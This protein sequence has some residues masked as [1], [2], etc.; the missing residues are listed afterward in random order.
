MINLRRSNER[1]SADHGWLQTKHTFSFANYYDPEQMGFSALRVI[2]D[3]L[4]HPGS[5]FDTHGHK[6]M[7]IISVVLEGAIAHKD[8]EGNVEQL[9]AGEFQLMSA[10]K[11]IFHSEF[12]PSK[13]E[14]LKLLQIWIEPNTFG[15]K[16]GYQ[17]KHFGKKIGITTI[18]SPDGRENS[19]TIKQDASLH[20]LVLEANSEL[21]FDI[22]PGRK[23][24][25][26]QVEGSLKVNDV[27]LSQGDGAKVSNEP[28]VL[29]AN[30][31]DK[32][33]VVLVF[34]LP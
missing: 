34:D 8:S 5:G 33:I 14:N 17:Q 23:L 9:P 2:N 21:K 24:Y 32:Q 7:E 29:L 6:D 10:G 1:G 19:F 20:Q 31:S 13:T 27:T 18:A 25:L 28:S 3:D 12:N 16:P 30:H 22:E 11:G 26:H 15:G 4:V